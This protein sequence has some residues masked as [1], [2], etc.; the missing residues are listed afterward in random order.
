MDN[1]KPGYTRVSDIAGAF[2]P[3][4]DIPRDV[5][6]NAANRGKEVHQLIHERFLN[7]PDTD[8]K[9]PKYMMS[10]ERFWQPYRNSEVLL[11]EKRLYYDSWMITGQIDMIAIINGAVTLIDW[12]CTAA[13]SP[14]WKIQAGGYDLLAQRAGFKIDNWIFVRLDKGGG[15]PQVI[16]YDYWDMEWFEKAYEFYMKFL[17]DQTCNLESE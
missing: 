9:W 4:R 5:L 14:H 16:Q 3:Y 6:E 11:Q 12:K 1:I 13:T 2:A 8:N 7:I 15:D 17:K 10:W